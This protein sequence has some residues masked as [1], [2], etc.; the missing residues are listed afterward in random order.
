MFSPGKWNSNNAVP[1]RVRRSHS[2]HPLKGCCQEQK[3][4]LCKKKGFF[5]SALL[6]SQLPTSVPLP[7]F[8]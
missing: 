2:G 8:L 7:Q 6:T 3:L 4:S 5:I 1:N